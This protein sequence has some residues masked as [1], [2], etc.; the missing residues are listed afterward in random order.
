MTFLI[1]SP[2]Y[3]E[4]FFSS[5]VFYFQFMANK[6]IFLPMGVSRVWLGLLNEFPTSFM[7]YTMPRRQFYF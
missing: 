1:S 6:R 7:G 2:A 5:E 3:V 4:V